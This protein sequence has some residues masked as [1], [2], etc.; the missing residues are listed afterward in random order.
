MPTIEPALLLTDSEVQFLQRKLGER[1]SQWSANWVQHPLDWELSVVGWSKEMQTDA[2]N[3]PLEMN[4]LLFQVLFGE[5]MA[6]PFHPIA[7][8]VIN[9]AKQA[10]SRMVF[11]T[12]DMQL[13]RSKPS[14]DWITSVQLRLQSSGQALCLTLLPEWVYH[15]MSD[16]SPHKT[17]TRF[18]RMQDALAPQ[19]LSLKIATATMELRVSD[20]LGLSIGDVI[21]I[22]KNAGQPFTM[23][24]GNT[25][26]AGGALCHHNNALAFNIQKWANKA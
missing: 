22:E 11:G 10:F 1:L 7:T 6:P 13:W 24:C 25:P 19:L 9:Q 20:L 18:T 2:D 21:P 4:N 26:V 12:A 16:R 14:Q 8:D 17:R 3:I 23:L 15:Q 5:K